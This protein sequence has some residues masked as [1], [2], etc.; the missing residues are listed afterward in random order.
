MS[1]RGAH[2]RRTGAL[3]PSRNVFDL[4]HEKKFTCYM[5]QLIPV[6]CD[7]VVPGDVF[8]IAV[9]N[10]L[11]FHP[12]IAPIFHPVSVF[13][14][15]F[16]VPYRIIW[17]L[18]TLFISG[19]FDGKF[20]KPLPRWEPDSTDLTLGSMWDYLGFPL[21]YIGDSD[22]L[23]PIDFP[24]RA[25][26]LI[27][28]E[29]YRD[30]FLQPRVGLTDTAE[31]E[32]YDVENLTKNNQIKFRNFVKDY[33]TSAQL[34]QQL[35]DAPGFPIV[36]NAETVWQGDPPRFWNNFIGPDTAT[37]RQLMAINRDTTGGSSS[38]ASTFVSGSL[39]QSGDSMISSGAFASNLPAQPI[40][41]H[42]PQSFLDW[43]RNNDVPL[44]TLSSFDVKE[45]REAFQLQKWME[46][47]QRSGVRYV[48]FLRSHFGITIP[49][50]TLQ[51][52][53][54]IGGV[55]FDVQVSEVL[56]TSSTQGGSASGTNTPQGTMAGH[57]LQYGGQYVGRYRVREFGLIMGIMSVM[58]TP[59][60]EDG[61]DRQWL[62]EVKEDFYF[63]EFAHLSE[64][65][66]YSGELYW[67]G[68][69]AD[70]SPFGFQPP[71]DEMRIK[72][73]MVMGRMRVSA[74][75]S[76]SFWHLGRSFADRPNL[77]E[78]FVQMDG[79]RDF[80]MRPFAVQNQEPCIVSWGN[81]IRAIR[82]MPHIGE[83]GL[84]DHF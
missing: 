25:Y 4:S 66:I 31:E 60:Y 63:P 62:R 79:T 9:N 8:K 21:R 2:H 73:N 51:R 24:K 46:R 33:F 30:Q 27:W 52:P 54:Y 75:L 57:G 82:P 3:R 34:D 40:S 18:W 78:E 29:F 35:G 80:A 17:K 13:G 10:V 7:E 19:G 1:K 6:M 83:P 50:S 55:K 42:M 77:N 74:P 28:N 64:Q 5:G 71:Y 72:R 56:Q 20:N 37:A 41:T 22:P 68:S 59:S 76:L 38:L 26:N 49:D 44:N 69:N 12:M 45:M 39:G 65:A 43:L 84:I 48:E 23:L 14:H 47:N 11:R 61:I 15:F 36:G 16:F 67:D 70:R 81:I 32:E 53:E 58:P